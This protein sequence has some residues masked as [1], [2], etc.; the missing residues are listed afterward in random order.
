LR[1]PKRIDEYKALIAP[2]VTDLDTRLAEAVAQ[3]WRP[4]GGVSVSMSVV[5]GGLQIIYAVLI[6]RTTE[7]SSNAPAVVDPIIEAPKL[8]EVNGTAPRPKR[9]KATQKVSE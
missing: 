3:N 1:C 6:M 7:P 8:V 9:R 5:D 2:S 4:F